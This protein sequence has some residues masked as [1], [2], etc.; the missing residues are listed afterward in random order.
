MSKHRKIHVAGK[1]LD[2][3]QKCGL[4]GQILFEQSKIDPKMYKIPARQVRIKSNTTKPFVLSSEGWK[5]GIRLLD[6][7][8]KL[9]LTELGATCNL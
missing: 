1:M 7:G 9:E 2:K 3:V 5:E 6:C 8:N 4:C